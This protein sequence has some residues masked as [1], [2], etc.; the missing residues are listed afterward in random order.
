MSWHEHVNTIFLSMLI[1]LARNNNRI[2]A[3][4]SEVLLSIELEVKLFGSIY[5][6]GALILSSCFAEYATSG[7]YPALGN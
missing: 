7:R 6:K 5:S 2:A 1:F 4:D 3:R